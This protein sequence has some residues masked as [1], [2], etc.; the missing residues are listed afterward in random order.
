MSCKGTPADNFTIETKQPAIGE[1]LST[2]CLEIVFF[3]P[4][5]CYLFKNNLLLILIPFEF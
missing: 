2:G 5:H 1:F 3:L 4:I